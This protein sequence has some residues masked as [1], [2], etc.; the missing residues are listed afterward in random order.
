LETADVNDIKHIRLAAHRVGNPRTP[1]ERGPFAINEQRDFCPV[2]EAKRFDQF[3]DCGSQGAV[4]TLGI[5]HRGEAGAATIEPELDVRMEGSNRTLEVSAHARRI[6][7]T[8]SAFDFIP[9]GHGL[10]S[11]SMTPQHYHCTITVTTH[12]TCRSSPSAL[13]LGC[14]A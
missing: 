13:E 3:C 14:S 9:R 12:Q 6:G 11:G 5:T 8:K 2:I 1:V 10:S 4:A 7:S